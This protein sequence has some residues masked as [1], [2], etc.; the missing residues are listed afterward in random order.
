MQARR[1]AAAARSVPLFLDEMGADVSYPQVHV[2]QALKQMFLTGPTVHELVSG[3]VRLLAYLTADAGLEEGC[4]RALFAA[5]GMPVSMAAWVGLEAQLDRALGEEGDAAAA[6]GAEAAAAALLGCPGA[7]APRVARALEALGRPQ[8][9]LSL[10]RAFPPSTPSDLEAAIRA[11]LQ[12]QALPEAMNFLSAAQAAGASE[13]ALSGLV[14]GSLHSAMP[15]GS[16]SKL[17][18]SGTGS[19]WEWAFQH[20]KV[21]RAIEQPWG[22][23]TERLSTSW[24]R[25]A[26]QQGTHAMA[27]EVLS[28]FLLQRGRLQ[29]AA[30]AAAVGAGAVQQH[31]EVDLEGYRSRRMTEVAAVRASLLETARQLVPESA[32][33]AASVRAVWVGEAARDEEVP[34][35]GPVSGSGG[36]S[37]PGVPM[38]ENIGH[39]R[40]RLWLLARSWLLRP[41]SHR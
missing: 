16:S 29:Q 22:P 26:E 32:A 14:G 21:Q 19:I 5:F 30:E 12:C 27:G 38:T 18:L 28:L 13:D 33:P 8:E 11:A 10:L 6:L 17:S 24:L 34:K 4:S 7:A 23:K 41:V 9:A 40:W 20:G 39:C 3:R 15:C 36:R 1:R 31:M 35:V 2:A 25:A 37:L